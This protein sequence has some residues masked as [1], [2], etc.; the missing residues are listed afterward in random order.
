MPT[1]AAEYT[2]RHDGWDVSDDPARIDLA[3]VHSWLSKESYWCEGIPLATTERAIANSLVFGLY[4]DGA[5]SGFARVVTDRATFAY[6]CDVW[7]DAPVRGKGLGTWLAECVFA[8][9]DLRGLRRFCLMT[10][11]AHGLYAKFG[12]LP[13][14]DPSRYM[15]IND[16][17]VYRRPQEVA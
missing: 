6:L 15:E 9:P 8:H 17:D 14:P 10:R 4:R 5:Q 12:F 2:C 7:I 16:R 13:M 11:D 3:R 1:T